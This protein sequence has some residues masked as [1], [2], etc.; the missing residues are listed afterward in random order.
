MNHRT[1]LIAGFLA[2]VPAAAQ[3]QLAPYTVTLSSKAYQSSSSTVT[4]TFTAIGP[5]PADDE[6]Q[7]TLKLP[8]TYNFYGEDYDEVYAYTNGVVAFQQ[9]SGTVSLLRPPSAVPRANDALDAYVAAVWQDLEYV[10]GTSVLRTET[11][12][13]SP[14]RTFVIEYENFRRKSD[15]T[16]DIDF[17]IEFDEDGFGFRV[18]YGTVNGIFGSTTAIEG[19]L[20]QDGKNLLGCLAVSCG[21][22]DYPSGQ[23]IE[24]DLPDEPDLYGFVEGP[25]GAAPGTSFDVVLRIEN[26]GLGSAGASAWELYLTDSPTAITATARRLDSG[27]VGALDRL[28]QTEVARTV[29][30]PADVPVAVRY[31]AIRVDSDDDVAEADE[32]NNDNVALTFGTGPDLTG[33]ITTPFVIGPGELIPI[34]IDARSDGAPHFDPVNLTFYLSADRNID[35]ND[36]V[37]GS[38][39]VTLPDGF[40]GSKL[41]SPT[42]PT[43]LSLRTAFVIARFDPGN[44]VPEIDELNNDVATDLPLQVRT[45]DIVVRRLDSNGRLYGGVSGGGGL[46]FEI[47]AE[48]ENEGG[49]R[50]DDLSVCFYLTAALADPPATDRIAE[51][52]GIS[53]AAGQRVTVRLTAVPDLL[54][55]G[56]INLAA[57]ADC[58]QVIDEDDEDDNYASRS[59]PVLAPGPDLAIAWTSTAGPAE[60]GQSYPIQYRLENLGS[61]DGLADVVLVVSGP[62]GS[63][64]LPVSPAPISVPRQQGQVRIGEPVLPSDLVSGTYALT[65]RTR[66]VSAGTDPISSNDRDGPRSVDLSGFGLAIVGPSAPSADLGQPYE[67]SF[68]ALGGD[69]TYTWRIEWD[70]GAPPGLTFDAGG[71]VSGVPEL[72]GNYPFMLEVASGELINQ[73]LGVITVVPPALP[74]TIATR[75]MPPAIVGEPYSEEVTILGGTPPYRFTA[76]NVPRGFTFEGGRLFGEAANACA[77]TFIL[78]VS[79]GRG[80]EVSSPL[81]LECIDPSNVIEIGLADLPSGL[82]DLPYEVAIPVRDAEAPMTFSIEGEIPP[83]LV[84]DTSGRLTGTP[85]Q[86]GAYPL[87]IAVVDGQGRFDRNPFVLQI[88]EAGSL[89]ILTE[90]LPGGT[91]GQAYTGLGGVPV[92]LEVAGANPDRPVVWTVGAGSLPPG[93]SLDGPLISGEPTDVGTWSFTLV[94]FDDSGDSAQRYYGIQVGDGSAVSTEGGCRC[95]EPRQA[96]VHGLWAVAAAVLLARRR[97]RS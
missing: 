19:E 79:D 2:L 32:T 80:E 96:P 16:S 59:V 11:V 36:D 84:F 8:F 69:G 6:G 25:A 76:Q 66:L 72:I 95:L 68:N 35:P 28:S 17:R 78:A 38:T 40:T 18:W 64:E 58:R 53:L 42:V 21:N 1:A 22:V 75:A 50:A 44:L 9:P 55:T 63:R 34:T 45:A 23:L 57:L 14:T 48:I 4:H 20:G 39:T 88:L 83:G 29:L 97:R 12:G 61:A 46:P 24:V 86:A 87:V 51:A 92:E 67:W 77:S 52:T 89:Q 47:V 10:A 74:L 91:V 3:A 65:L 90:L 31:L 93:L 30:L 15:P 33:D 62:S 60:A 54:G 37:L 81:V 26:G 5:F 73:T 43:G 13:L 7:A 71:R 41:Y 94:A 70:R 56:S 27:P 49:A 85:T 82:V